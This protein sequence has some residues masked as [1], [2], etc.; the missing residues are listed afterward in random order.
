MEAVIIDQFSDFT[1]LPVDI[2]MTCRLAGTMTTPGHSRVEGA[3]L[4][5]VRIPSEKLY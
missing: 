4:E 5:R 1:K 2:V 3:M